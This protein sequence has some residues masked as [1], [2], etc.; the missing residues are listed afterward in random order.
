MAKK[1]GTRS[2]ALKATYGYDLFLSTFDEQG[3]AER[4]VVFLQM[5]AA[6]ALRAVGTDR[7][8]DRDVRDYNLWIREEMPVILVLFDA[9]KERAVWLPLDTF[10]VAD[11][12]VFESELQKAG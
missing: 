3:Y 4:G 12:F 2:S 6:E 8:F 1:K 10:G 11:P 5:K 7:V 9:A